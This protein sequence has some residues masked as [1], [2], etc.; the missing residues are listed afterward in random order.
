MCTV[1]YRVKS[2]SLFVKRQFLSF[3]RKEL[4]F[5]MPSPVP[6]FRLHIFMIIFLFRVESM[7][8]VNC[9]EKKISPMRNACFPKQFLLEKG[10]VRHVT[11]NDQD[12]LRKIPRAVVQKSALL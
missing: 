11:G 2:S 3:A 8:A 7:E 5:N 4:N 1:P 12:Y 9:V 6:F 10:P